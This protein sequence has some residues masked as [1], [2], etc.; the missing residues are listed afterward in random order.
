MLIFLSI[1]YAT[2]GAVFVGVLNHMVASGEADDYEF[3]VENR[4]VLKVIFFFFWPAVIIG[5]GIALLTEGG[6]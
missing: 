6:D 5:A 4:N 3:I 2:M 1:L